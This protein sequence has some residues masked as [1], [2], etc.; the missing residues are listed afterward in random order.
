MKRWLAA[1]LSLAMGANGLVM[2]GAGRWWYGAV[3]G[4]T[5]TGPFNAHFVRDIGAAYLTVGLA[6]GWLAIAGSAAARGAALAAAT[7]LALHAGIHLTEAATD[8]MG[9]A[10]LARDFA[11]VIL[12]AI[13]AALVA[14]PSN[15]ILETRHA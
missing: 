13:L 12:P 3:A 14:W 2:L 1:I 8:P 10:H 15:P 11:G 5:E 9:P 4:V 6:L 7:F